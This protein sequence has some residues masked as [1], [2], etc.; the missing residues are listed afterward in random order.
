MKKD[1][2]ITC[3][4]EGRHGTGP[5][6]TTE[7]SAERDRQAR[8]AEGAEES[9][10]FSRRPHENDFVLDRRTSLMASLQSQY[11]PRSAWIGSV[12]PSALNMMP[13][14]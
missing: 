9:I 11:V 1:P 8:Q 6:G 13:R 4:T 14:A 10:V 2:R 5:N 7:C 12:V 3:V